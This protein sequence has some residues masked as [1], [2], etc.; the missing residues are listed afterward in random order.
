MVLYRF[1][2]YEIVNDS[3]RR[4]QKRGYENWGVEVNSNDESE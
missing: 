3:D 1:A 2:G 4:G